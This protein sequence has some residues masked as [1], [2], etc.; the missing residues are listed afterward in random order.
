MIENFSMWAKNITLAVIVVSI[1]EMLLPNNKIKKYIKVVMG[2][3]ILFNILSPIIGQDMSFDLNEFIEKNQEDIAEIEG[4]NKEYQIDQ[5]S[6]NQRLMQIAKQELE[7]DIKSK[8]QEKGYIVNRCEVD[9]EITTETNIKQIVLDLEKS[10]K[11]KKDNS[12]EDVENKLV[13]EIQ[14]VKKV[15]IGDKK[16]DDKNKSLTLEE[17]KQI[18]NILMEE[19]EVKEK[20]LKING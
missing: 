15:Q 4:S 3:Y 12:Q 8:I 6:M 20:C 10:E 16:K 11:I 2:L 1:F 14:K 13:E 18:K 7:K 5:N 9:L 19:Y 17:V